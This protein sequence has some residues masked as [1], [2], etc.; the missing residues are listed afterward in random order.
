[1]VGTNHRGQVETGAVDSHC[2]LFLL[3][4]DP[5]RVVEGAREAGVGSLVC[6]GIDPAS[7]RRS[8]ELAESFRGVF[9]TAGM[10]PHTASALDEAGGAEIEELLSNPQVLAV[11]ETGL[12]FY[13]MHSPAEEQERAFRIHARWSL[14]FD[15]PIV[16]HVR[17]AWDEALRI[18]SEERPERV[19]LHCFSG[20]ERLA[21]EAGGRGYFMSFAGNV[22]YPKNDH[23]RRAAR[24]V[25]REL[26]LAETDSPFLAPQ[27]VRGREN[28]P[29]N[30][31]S[32]IESLAEIRGEDPN[33]V[34]ALT[35]ANARAAFPGL[36]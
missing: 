27:A 34:L 2:H 29:A 5:Q 6:V 28:T 23:L 14:E 19:V 16:V 32:V 9:A 20:D 4:G 11:G 24:A 15:K 31:V 26:L 21:E 1:M 10:H 17:D 8:V 30:V 22:T 35:A 12:D 25:R 13:R 7:S 18:L 3:L 33:G 36:R